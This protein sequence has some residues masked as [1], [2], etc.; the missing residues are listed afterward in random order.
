MT[1]KHIKRIQAQK[2]PKRLQ[3]NNKATQQDTTEAK[4]PIIIQS[5][6]SLKLLGVYVDSHLSFKDNITYISS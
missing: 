2:K 4:C 1:L 6:N 5:T 3:N